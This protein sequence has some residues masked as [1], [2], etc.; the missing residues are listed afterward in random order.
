MTWKKNLYFSRFGN[1]CKYLIIETPM[2]DKRSMEIKDAYRVP[3]IYYLAL[4]VFCECETRIW[5]NYSHFLIT[6]FKVI[7]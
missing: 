3:Y 5:S 7:G 6:A 4:N 2:N 1:S